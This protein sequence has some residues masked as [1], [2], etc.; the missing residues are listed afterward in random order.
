MM[1]IWHVVE[2]NVDSDNLSNN[3]AKP[4][5]D[6]NKEDSK[7]ALSQMILGSPLWDRSTNFY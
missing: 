4:P 2:E 1:A 5:I 3:D 6:N 7:G